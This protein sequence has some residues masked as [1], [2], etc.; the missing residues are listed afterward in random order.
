MR[1][2]LANRL[3]KRAHRD[4]ARAQDMIVDAVTDRL[5]RAVLH[6]GTAIW[7]CYGANRF[8]DDL[9]FYFASDEL[10]PLFRVIEKKGFEI[11]KRKISERSVYARL[12]LQRTMVR[13][14]ATFQEKKGVLLDYECIDGRIMTV[15]GLT[16]EELCKEKAATYLKR[17]KIRDLW[18]VFFILRLL[19]DLEPVKDDLKRLI[20][21]YQRPIDEEDL[22]AVIIEGIAPSAEEMLNYIR[23]KWENPNI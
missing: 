13:L 6:G 16:R 18:D 7:R 12:Q 22:K 17:R 11:K 9:D 10:D 4:I 5:P 19:P 20:D 8:S 1:I 3:K 2:P 21:G 23:R 15:Y 14:E